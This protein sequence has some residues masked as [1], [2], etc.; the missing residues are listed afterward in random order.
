MT[1]YLRYQLMTASLL[2]ILLLT[3]R[4]YTTAVDIY[5]FAYCTDCYYGFIVAN[6][7]GSCP[8][9][10]QPYVMYPNHTINNINTTRKLHT[11]RCDFSLSVTFFVLGWDWL[12]V[13]SS[14][15]FQ[16]VISC[17]LSVVIVNVFVFVNQVVLQPCHVASIMYS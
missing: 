15:G 7:H 11:F 8:P 2:F 16:S 4:Y 9:N 10:M 17:L 14:A 3:T 12:P 1:F 5:L 13:A 6:K